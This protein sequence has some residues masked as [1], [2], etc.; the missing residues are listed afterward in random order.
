M[1]SGF[2]FEKAH[3]KIL[4]I[5]E[6]EWM[7]RYKKWF[8]SKKVLNDQFKNFIKCFTDILDNNTCEDIINTYDPKKFNR[9]LVG[10]DYEIS[11][12]R[13]VYEN[14]LD[15]KFENIIFKKVGDILNSYADQFKWFRTSKLEDSGYKHL[16]YKGSDKE[17]LKCMWII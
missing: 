5:L 6:S 17:N 9:S 2:Y 3:A 15:P 10:N 8:W 16:C 1:W 12:A 14:F 4:N 13:K 11:D 7:D